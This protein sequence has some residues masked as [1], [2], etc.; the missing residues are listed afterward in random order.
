MPGH[1]VL[2]VGD[3]AMG[4]AVHGG[5]VHLVLIAQQD[6][7][8][9]PAPGAA[10]DPVHLLG[11]I[12]SDRLG[13]QVAYAHHARAGEANA[14][15]HVLDFKGRAHGDQVFRARV[16]GRHQGERAGFLRPRHQAGQGIPVR[17]A[18]CRQAL[19]CLD[20]HQRLMR[21]AVKHAACGQI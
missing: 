14:G 9:V 20:L 15:A 17:A 21:A 11:V 4:H 3:I 13:I 1:P 7:P 19:I 2:A 12:R 8:A 18:A 10:V 6:G 16:P 5:G